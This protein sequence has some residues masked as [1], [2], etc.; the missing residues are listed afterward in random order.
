MDKIRQE[1]RKKASN[2]DG[3]ARV[4]PE[5]EK[6]GYEKLDYSEALIKID[7]TR[8]RQWQEIHANVILAYTALIE[9]FEGKRPPTTKEVADFCDLA[10]GTVKAH[11][12]EISFKPLEHPLRILTDSVIMNIFESTRNNAASQKLWMQ[13]MEGFSET[14]TMDL[15]IKEI[16]PIAFVPFQQKRVQEETK[17]LES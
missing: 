3:I 13:L 5:R 16:P 6:K 14:N 12:A 4:R 15:K 7:K 11:L 8:R 10:V 9:R 2:F 1:N 17:Q